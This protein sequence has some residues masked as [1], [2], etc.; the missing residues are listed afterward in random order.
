M[1]TERTIRPRVLA[2]VLRLQRFT[3]QEIVSTAGLRDSKQAWVQLSKLEKSGHLTSSPRLEQGSDRSVNL[4]SIVTDAKKQAELVAAATDY[5]LQVSAPFSGALGRDAIIAASRT[6]DEVDEELSSIDVSQASSRSLDGISRS[7]EDLNSRLDD[8]RL[9]IETAKAESNGS[10]AEM[11]LQFTTH[12]LHAVREML[13][14]VKSTILRRHTAL[15]IREFV[16]D[17]D[18]AGAGA[19]MENLQKRLAASES[20][21]SKEIACDVLSPAIRR[22]DMMPLVLTSHAMRTY[23]LKLIHYCLDRYKSETHSH[24]WDYNLLNIDF[25][26]GRF[27]RVYENFRHAF[28][29]VV[30]LQRPHHVSVPCR[31]FLYEP[32]HLTKDVI[33]L[34]LKT[35]EVSLVSPSALPFWNWTENEICPLL[36]EPLSEKGGPLT[37]TVV[38]KSN[39]KEGPLWKLYAYGP[40]SSEIQQWPGAPPLRV[41][42]SVRYFLQIDFEI[43]QVADGL[44]NRKGVLVIQD[45]RAKASDLVQNDVMVALRGCEEVSLAKSF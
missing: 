38:L 26:L 8:V 4:Y 9:D 39:Q 40:L 10:S 36:V 44:R 6:L 16:T 15:V 33:S 11:E 18:L 21:F 31:M 32:S 7:V 37:R 1:K 14:S 12:R 23:D 30:K 42:A 22:Q 28:A 34:L 17:A 24:W 27:K 41:A 13:R 45:H 3:V 20:G 25:L 2:A 5:G 29:S 19:N 35:Y 43:R